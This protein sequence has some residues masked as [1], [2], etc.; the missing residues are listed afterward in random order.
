MLTPFV[1]QYEGPGYPEA[2]LEVRGQQDRLRNLPDV[3]RGRWRHGECPAL[4]EGDDHGA[5]S[6]WMERSARCME[7]VELGLI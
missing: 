3:Q 2:V 4:S 5:A 1:N 6:A 7:L